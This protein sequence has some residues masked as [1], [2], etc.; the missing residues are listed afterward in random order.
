MEAMDMDK[1]WKTVMQKVQQK[2]IPLRYVETTRKEL[3]GKSRDAGQPVAYL[4]NEQ[5]EIVLRMLVA[6]VEESYLKSRLDVIHQAALL[7]TRELSINLADKLGIEEEN[8]KMDPDSGAVYRSSGSAGDQPVGTTYYKTL[9][10]YGALLEQAMESPLVAHR[11][12][13]DDML[14]AWLRETAQ[15]LV[16]GD[17]KPAIR[18]ALEDALADPD[19]A[20]TLYQG[21]REKGWPTWLIDALEVL[22]GKGSMGGYREH[23]L[24]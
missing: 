22:A 7:A 19:Y 15:V 14:P 21:G 18:C 4:D 12:A 10:G 9:K 1:I 13:N 3:V 8:V 5:S 17:L 11:M 2:G 16:S 20:A 23:R 24:Q 6:R